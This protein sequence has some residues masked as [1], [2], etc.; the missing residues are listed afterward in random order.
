MTLLQLAFPELDILS[1]LDSTSEYQSFVRSFRYY[2]D[3]APPSTQ[4]GNSLH[5]DWNLLTLVWSDRPGLE[6]LHENQYLDFSDP[7]PGPGLVCN[8]GDF[9][10]SVSKGKL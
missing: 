7:L 9:L 4:I 6:V 2:P 5:T 1:T 3:H 8:F 10:S